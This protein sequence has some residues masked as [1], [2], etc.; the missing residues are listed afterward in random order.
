MNRI[1]KEFFNESELIFIGY[2]QKYES[3][4]MNVFQTLTQHGIK[5]YPINTRSDAKFTIKVFRSLSELPKTPTIA[6]VLTNQENTRK[7][8]PQLKEIGI[9]KILFQ[10]KKN[11][12]QAALDLCQEL[13]IETALGCPMMVFGSGIHKI[14]AFFTGVR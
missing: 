13:K 14:H 11:V 10:S 6:Y 7:L 3:F 2:S 4:C 1:T 5:V 12:D 8:I 9:K